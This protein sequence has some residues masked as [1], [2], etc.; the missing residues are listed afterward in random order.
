MKTFQT[1]GVTP[2]ISDLLHKQGIDE[3]TEIQA[4]SIPA[5][6]KGRDVL[7]QAQTGTGKTLAFLL[8]ALQQIR[9]DLSREQVLIVAPTR[10]LAKQ[11]ADVAETLAP[12]L[13]VDVLSLIGGKTIENQLQKL[14]R[15]PHIIIGTPGRLLDHCNRNSLDLSN[16]KRVIVDEADQMLQAGFLED[17]DMLISM[18]PKSRQLLFFSATIPD[19][20][21]NLAKKHMTNPL[22]LNVR[23]GE[24]IALETIEQRIYMVS[25]EHKLDLLCR[26]LTDMNSYL[27]IVFCN[28]KERTSILASDL[29]ARGFNI[30]EL[31]GD[32]SQGRRTQVLR[33]FAKA[34]TQI[35]VA[36]DI[37][38]RGIDIEGITHV[39]S[40]DVPHDVDYYIHRIGRTGRAGSEGLAIMFATAADETWVRRI[41]HNIQATI[42]KYA[43]NGQVRV[44]AANTAPKRKKVFKD[45]LPAST[46]Q[47]TKSK[48]HK[49]LHKGGDNRRRRK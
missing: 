22:V 4:Q 47:A 23:E 5:L 24:T 18:T 42:T 45:K 46:Y 49:T 11:I 48:R 40:Y 9:T 10:E 27:A 17:I 34:K 28:T 43:A 30:G 33:D 13:S 36:T 39:F 37:A 26:M 12:A 21:R 14:H 6:F 35:L 1:L 16:V 15:H 41:E 25:E 8:P 20:I 29:I 31:H 2:F 44:K 32:M 7:A 3:P 38:A 19:K